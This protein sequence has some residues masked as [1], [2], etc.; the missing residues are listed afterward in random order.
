MQD[1]AAN[2]ICKKNNYLS[3]ETASNNFTIHENH[4][5]AQVLPTAEAVQILLPIVTETASVYLTVSCNCKSD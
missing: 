3:M 5:C 4:L 1:Q 2:H